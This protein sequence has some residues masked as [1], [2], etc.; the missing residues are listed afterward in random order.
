MRPLNVL[1]PVIGLAFFAAFQAI[2]IVI[3][4]ASTG[5]FASFEYFLLMYIA[6]SIVAIL[7]VLRNSRIGFLVATMISALL[8]I[9]I[10]LTPKPDGLLDAPSNHRGTGE[11]VDPI[12][13]SPPDTPHARLLHSRLA[14][15]M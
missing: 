6:I 15:E 10:V 2:V 3:I 7:A 5:S 11:F 4:S 12:T 14:G 9:F 8:A 13:T 1:I